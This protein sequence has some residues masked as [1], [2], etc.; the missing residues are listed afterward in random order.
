MDK[1]LTRGF[2]LI[3]MLIVVAIIA[4]LAGVV[5]T[6]ITGFQASA[7]DTKRIGDL[8]NVQNYLELYFNRCGYYPGSIAGGSCSTS[9]PAS[10]TA[11][12]SMME[13]EGFTSS[14]P[15]DPVAAQTYYYGS[16]ADNLQ[17]VL[18]ATLERDNNVLS[19][20]V[21]G[22]VFGVDCSDAGLNLCVQS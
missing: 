2:T 13:S 8:R 20:D 19:N 15:Q 22:T 10:W 5:L 11:L 7:R 18:G 14:F 4:I 1:K 3:E 21:D 16:S 17:Y 6:G 12:E 9:D